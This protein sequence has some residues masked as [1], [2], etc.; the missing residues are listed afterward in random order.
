M[1]NTAEQAQLETAHSLAFVVV[2]EAFEL[3]D[4]A[5]RYAM[6]TNP[7]RKKELAER[8]FDH[9]Y[10]LENAFQTLRQ[11]RMLFREMAAYADGRCKIGY[12]LEAS[13]H[14]A[15]ISL[16]LT[17]VSQCGNVMLHC[18][19]PEKWPP[20]TNGQEY[21]LPDE[22]P[23][24]QDAAPH[25]DVVIA[26]F[27]KN[28]DQMLPLDDLNE[29]APRLEQEYARLIQTLPRDESS[30]HKG[31]SGRRP[32]T[33]PLARYAN[34]RRKRKPPMPWREIAVEYLSEHPVA[35]NANGKP[36]TAQGIRDAWR[37]E[38]AD[39]KPKQR[40]KPTRKN[41]QSI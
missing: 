22:L 27:Q 10:E 18:A 30:A 14:S 38:Y 4:L 29:L 28:L 24:R 40:K 3:H 12:H 32:T 20:Q 33:K 35:T 7:A 13:A 17:I 15:V 19:F 2:G 36:L 31:R 1:P 21:S 37:R 11:A 16:G 23:G 9:L 26:D 6:A 8:F 41:A 5:T 25:A 39:K 34:T